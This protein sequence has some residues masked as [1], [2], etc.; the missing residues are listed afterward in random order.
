MKREHNFPLFEVQV[1]LCEK[2]IKF[3]PSI[4]TNEDSN[5][6]KTVVT[7]IDNILSTS[8]SMNG[9]GQAKTDSF[10]N[11]L[12]GLFMLIFVFWE[13]YMCTG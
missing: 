4:D 1:E 11:V 9:I 10:E 6:Y 2:T 8:N 12:E 7:L 13:C 3:K 5:L